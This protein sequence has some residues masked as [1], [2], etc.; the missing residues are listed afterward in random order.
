M[1]ECN[2]IRPFLN[3]YISV[4]VPH[5]I[6]PGKLFFYYGYLRYVDNIELKLEMS[7]GVKIIPLTRIYDVHLGG[8]NESR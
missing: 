2:E 4:G 5:D 7:N 8:N 1:I 6:I 3:K